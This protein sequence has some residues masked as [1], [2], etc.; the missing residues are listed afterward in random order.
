MSNL[1]WLREWAGQHEAR[2]DAEKTAKR[3]R[4]HTKYE[5]KRL[6]QQGFGFAKPV[7][8]PVYAD[9]PAV[10]TYTVKRDYDPLL[11]GRPAG[12]RWPAT[13]KEAQRG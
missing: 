11:Y 4:R 6:K 12:S 8:Q 3:T 1:E 10:A 9:W 13:D 7:E 5:K 2:K